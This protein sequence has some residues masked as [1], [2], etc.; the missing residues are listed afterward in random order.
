MQFKIIH[1]NVDYFYYFWKL[2]MILVDENN[3]EIIFPFFEE[4]FVLSVEV[5]LHSQVSSN[6]HQVN[7]LETLET[8][9]SSSRNAAYN[10]TIIED[11]MVKNVV[12][13]FYHI[14]KI[15]KEKL[16]FKRLLLTKNNHTR[17]PPNKKKLV[18]SYFFINFISFFN[19]FLINIG[20]N[21]GQY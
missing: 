13:Q 18:S 10:R 7:V 2:L 8:C 1:S 15:D 9:V 6:I 17:G 3:N 20:G 14:P 21:Y 4:T 12:K 11:L 5:F 16:I 19:H